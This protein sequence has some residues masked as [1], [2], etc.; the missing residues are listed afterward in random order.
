MCPM[1]LEHSI[2]VI[3]GASGPR[4]KATDVDARVSDVMQGY[5]T[6]FAKT[7]SPNNPNDGELPKW[8]R[9]DPASRAYLEF[10]DAGP[11]AKEGLRRTQC[12]LFVKHIGGT[13]AK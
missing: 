10:S 9:F 1:Y 6:N 4:A 13:K 12:A 5:W 7:G 8:P 11:R 2:S 3:V